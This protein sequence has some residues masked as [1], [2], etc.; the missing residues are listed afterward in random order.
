M[1]CFFYVQEFSIS[2]KISFFLYH[3]RNSFLFALS[4]FVWIIVFLNCI[5]IFLFALSFFC[6]LELGFC[7]H[8]FIYLL[9]CRPF[10]ISI[11]FYLLFRLVFFGRFFFWPLRN[12]FLI[13][14]VVLL[15]SVIKLPVI[16]WT[17]I[18]F[19]PSKGRVQWKDSLFIW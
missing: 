11:E 18:S 14:F 10:R 1:N 3:L 16:W 9:N 7:N 6:F 19:S 2:N 12:N 15:I 13:S 5:K 4:F 17:F 8:F